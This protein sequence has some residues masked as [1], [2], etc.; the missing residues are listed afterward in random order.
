M[1]SYIIAGI[2]VLIT[3]ACPP[4]GIVL[5]AIVSFFGWGG[6]F[7]F[8]YTLKKK[9]KNSKHKYKFKITSKEIFMLCLIIPYIV[10]NFWLSKKNYRQWHINKKNFSK[11][12]C[13]S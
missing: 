9:T 5:I 2:I 1:L 3:V 8:K 13:R 6:F 10:K 11:N 12:F 7:M 4:L